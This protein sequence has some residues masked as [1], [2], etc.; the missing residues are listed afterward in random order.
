M[1]VRAL[2]V[3][4]ERSNAIGSVE[5]ECTPFGLVIAYLGVGAFSEGYAPGALTHGTL[6]SIPY[7]DIKTARFEGPRLYLELSPTTTPHHK[8]VLT[9][10]SVG[11]GTHRHELYRQRVIL[12]ASAFAFALVTALVAALLVPRVSPGAS[13]LLALAIAA[14]G[15]TAV[16]AIG[17]FVD[18]KLITGQLEGEAAQDALAA[19]LRVYVPNLVRLDRPPPKPPKAL[20]LPDFQG[21]LPRT[22]AAIAITLTAGGLAAVLVANWMVRSPERRQAQLDSSVAGEGEEEPVTSTPE[23]I[24]LEAPA[25][26]N[27]A[28]PAAPPPSPTLPAAQVPS[29][30]PS[31]SA[32]EP[33][34]RGGNCSCERASSALWERSIP[35]LSV[36]VL[37]TR[38]RQDGRRKRLELDIAVVNNSGS[39]MNDVTLRVNF[40]ERDP[41]PGGRRHFSRHR[42]LFFEGPLA[43]GQ[44]IKWSTDARGVEFELENPV[45]GDIGP[46]G[47]EAAP[48]DAFAELLNANHRPV[49]MHAAMMLAYLGDPRARDAALKLQDALREEEAPYLR[50]VLDAVDTLWPCEVEITENGPLRRVSSC[51]YNASSQKRDQLIVKVNA[52]E[53]EVSLA[54]PVGAPPA[55]L[56]E[57]VWSVPGP[58]EPQQGARVELDLDLAKIKADTAQ[59]FEFLVG[60]Q[61]EL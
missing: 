16:L 61:G 57:S 19:E 25:A 34:R 27:P 45:E 9:G 47:D 46:G 52:L 3:G 5:L 29:S 30:S 53:S 17:F 50:R 6:V 51:I 13:A 15:A 48:A 41:G 18:R 26:A 39:D 20:P 58:L 22:T 42:V 7:P 43:P 36:L 40:Y 44:A 4:D 54:H 38:L 56:G 35:K 49:R 60:R 1:K 24:S 8:L 33:L 31:A 23:A 10:F 12:R 14:I 37:S 32:P 59:A 55:I 2:A 11:D 28:P 21:F